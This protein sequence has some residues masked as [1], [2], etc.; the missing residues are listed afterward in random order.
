MEFIELA[1]AESAVVSNLP[2]TFLL[3]GILLDVLTGEISFSIR[4]DRWAPR[5]KSDLAGCKGID[6]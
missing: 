6:G 5:S 1:M 3:V 2:A 4:F